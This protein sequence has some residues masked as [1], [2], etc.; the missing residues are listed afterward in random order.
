MES[1]LGG[2]L[3]Q[4]FRLLS[5]PCNIN[6]GKRKAVPKAHPRLTE[7]A[8]Y[9][10]ACGVVDF[11]SKIVRSQPGEGRLGGGEPAVD[12]VTGIFCAS[13]VLGVDRQSAD[14]ELCASSVQ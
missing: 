1:V 6:S 9:T 7:A 8:Q 10:T 4:E 2:H 13:S 14:T 5:S 3:A 12:A 11:A